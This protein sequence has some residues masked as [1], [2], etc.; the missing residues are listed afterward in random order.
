[1]LKGRRSIDWPRPSSRSLQLKN[2]SSGSYYRSLAHLFIEDI[3]GRAS[4]LELRLLSQPSKVNHIKLLSAFIRLL[5]IVLADVIALVM[6]SFPRPAV[7]KFS[8]IYTEL[9]FFFGK[10]QIN[11]KESEMSN[12]RTLCNRQR[13]NLSYATLIE[14]SNSPNFSTIQQKKKRKKEKKKKR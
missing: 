10:N 6:R 9:H 14:N 4:G 1:M 3:S 13:K 11:Q 5:R 8:R 12:L 7:P 2:S